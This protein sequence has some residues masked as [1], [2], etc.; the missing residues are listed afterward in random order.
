[1]NE[2]NKIS[3]FK[4]K[5]ELN[6]EKII[7]EYS[8]YVFK[9]IKNICGN[10]LTI[11]DIEEIILDVFLVIWKNREI[12]D[13][14]KDIKPYLASV[15]H[16]LTKKKLSTIL[17]DFKIVEY[18]EKLINNIPSINDMLDAKLKKDELDHILDNL[19]E[20][21]YKIFTLF[22]YFSKKMKEISKEL[23]ISEVKVKVK[24]HRIRNKIKKK[25]KERGY[26]L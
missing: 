15:T 26:S 1:M 21:E 4:Y 18:E 6:I 12:L 3:H 7:K 20:E 13:D 5:N 16:N 9:I 25:I 19:S 23:G 24:L 22:Y 17:K 11:E 14:D 2:R 8:N 10:N